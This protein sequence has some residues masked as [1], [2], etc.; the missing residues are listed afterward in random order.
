MPH[1]MTYQDPA[2]QWVE[3]LPLGNGKLGAMVYGNPS[4]ERFCLNDEGLWS[5]CPVMEQNPEAKEVLPEL[6]AAIRAKDFVQAEALA[7]RMQGPETASYQP[8]GDLLIQSSYRGAST[9]TLDFRTAVHEVRGDKLKVRSFIND[10][11]VVNYQS[12]EPLDFVLALTTPHAYSKS[13]LSEQTICLC[14]RGPQA[15]PTSNEV[16]PTLY[17]KTDAEALAPLFD[18]ALHFTTD[19]EVTETR[20]K[21]EA[22][23]PLDFYCEGKRKDYV[24]EQNLKAYA[25]K[26]ARTLNLSLASA[27][28][29]PWTKRRPDPQPGE[30]LYIADPASATACRER[31]G[32]RSWTNCSTPH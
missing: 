24:Q 31:L 23:P 19:G 15:C 13:E 5:G 21:P 3:A 27:V 17:A 4:C 8:L 26:G 22:A 6:R 9:R 2:K 30:P 20:W 11:L 1:Q 25:I 7:H 12:E 14:G 28:G 32:R 10:V 29:L 16:N 18:L